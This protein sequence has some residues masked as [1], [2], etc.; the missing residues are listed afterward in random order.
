MRAGFSTG[1]RAWLL[2]VEANLEAV[3]SGLTLPEGEFSAGLALPNN[4]KSMKLPT[5]QTLEDCAVR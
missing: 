1:W 2:F 3:E 4:A 5:S